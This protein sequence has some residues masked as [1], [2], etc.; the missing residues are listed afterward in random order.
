[1]A[2]TSLSERYV[3]R[4]TR[5][6]PESVGPDA[7]RELR[8]T[9]AAMTADRVAAGAEPEEAERSALTELGDPDVLARQH[10][11]RADHLI[12]PAVYPAYVRLLKLLLTIVLP[13][14]TIATLLVQLSAT[15][16]GLRAA[17]GESAGVLFQLAV[18]LTFWVT[19]VFVLIERGR[20][21]GERDRPLSDWSPDELLATDVPWRRVGLGEM[22]NDAGFSIAV[23]AL[24]VW[25]F[26]GVGERGVQV[27]DP[28]LAVGWKAAVVGLL[29]LDVFLTVLTW[30][31]DRWTVRLAAASVAANVVTAAVLLRL[32]LGDRLL[33][34]LP[35]E[36]GEAFGWSSD[37]TVPVR[38]VAAV[39]VGICAWDAATALLRARRTLRWRRSGAGPQDQVE[40]GS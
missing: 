37:W 29:L 2:D 28:A 9:L 39:V 6:L 14:A 18:Q 16:T 3:W 8:G 32:L 34:D 19:L 13:I 33:T 1:M 20:S 4:V 24:V 25:Q 27:L 5:S 22:L 15:G 17:V 30:G 21:E 38:V 31:A 11:G 26:A 35:A 36:F 7:A 40:P 12:G 23:A 10:G